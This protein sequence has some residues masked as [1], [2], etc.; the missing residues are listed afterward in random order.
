MRPLGHPGD[1]LAWV[2]AWVLGGEFGVFG[3]KG[4]GDI[5]EEDQPQGDMLVVRGLD[6]AVPL[7]SSTEELRLEAEVFGCVFTRRSRLPLGEKTT[8]FKT[9]YKG[10]RGRGELSV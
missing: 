1:V 5:L 8:L 2:L 9:A 4:N 6:V 3:G 10:A 7:T